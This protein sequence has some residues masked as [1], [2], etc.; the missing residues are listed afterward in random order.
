M[1]QP[2]AVRTLLVDNY[3][4][5]TY[6]LYQILAEV[7]GVPPVVISNDSCSVAEIED[8]LVSHGVHNIVIS[9]GPGTPER[10]GDVG[11]CL[12]LLEKVRHLPVLGVCLGHQLLAQLYGGKVSPAPEPVHGRLSEL[13]HSG[14]P[15]YSGVPTGAGSGFQ[16]VRYHSLVVEK[17][18]LPDCLEITSWT[19]GSHHA[20]QLHEEPSCSS[21]G[22]Q[23]RVQTRTSPGD[24]PPDALVMGLAHKDLPQYGVQFHPESVATRYGIAVLQN[25]RDLTCRHLGL[26]SPPGVANIIGPPGADFGMGPWPYGHVKRAAEGC[27]DVALRL[28]NVPTAKDMPTEEQEALRSLSTS[29]LSSCSTCQPCAGD[30]ADL[31]SSSSSSS[32]S[33]RGGLPFGQPLGLTY[34]RIS[35]VLGQVGGAQAVFEALV[36]PGPDTW[37]LDSSSRDRG[38]FSYMGRPWG[39]LWRRITYKLPPAGECYVANNRPPGT[40]TVSTPDRVEMEVQTPFMDYLEQELQDLELEVDGKVAEDLPFNFWGGFVGYLGYEMKAECGGELCHDSPFPDAAWYF[41][42]R[43]IAVDHQEG[44]VYLVA[45]WA[46]PGSG[47]LCPR[48]DINNGELG[49]PKGPGQGEVVIEHQANGETGSDSPWL[50]AMGEKASVRPSACTK[51][52]RACSNS[53]LAAESWLAE[54][55]IKMR[56]LQVQDTVKEG[57]RSP[58]GEEA[59]STSGTFCHRPVFKLRHC[60]H[61]YVEHIKACQVALREGESYEICLTNMMTRPQPPSAWELYRVLRVVNPAPYGAW[62]NLGGRQPLS[63]CCSS[64]ERF[65]RGDRGRMLEARPIKGTAARSSDPETDREAALHLLASEK[66]RAENLM[67][68]DLLR[69]DL[70]RVCETGSVH[71]P[72]LMELE[73]FATVHQLVSTVRGRRREGVSI[74]DCVRAAFPGGSMTGAPKVRTMHIIDEL[75]GAARGVYSG[76]I[77]FISLNDTFDLNIAIRTAVVDSSGI[78][79]GAGGAIVVQSEVESEYEEMMLKA[80]PLLRAVKIVDNGGGPETL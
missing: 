53:C 52:P 31:S 50:Q 70:G 66:D 28:P 34:K 27:P 32:S 72:G 29:S 7:N 4:S 22:N 3:D 80:R 61:E 14:H 76:C 23:G 65:L 47:Q 45:L 46:K 2:C 24:L 1:P 69:N 21:S 68:V 43:I 48:H 6:N 17:T 73:S 54:M 71:V 30:G 77:G 10:S 44:D 36:G 20:L 37:W 12:A 8:L 18:S 67:I 64:P 39:P 56:E 11:V 75:E 57:I 9:P 42:D 16:V 63:I 13:A 40:L 25:F 38:R 58:G 60:H 79:I 59:T 51:G 74:M 55:E 78:S 15:L 26:M 41:V 62:I 35:G 5:Y 33:D 49:E 19:C